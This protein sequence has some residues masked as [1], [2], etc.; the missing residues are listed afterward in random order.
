LSNPPQSVKRSWIDS[1][2]ILTWILEKHFDYQ[3]GWY[4]HK[5]DERITDNYL[6]LD[7]LIEWL[8]K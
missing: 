1:L 8:R 6:T 5:G 7:D 2:Y 3:S 4:S